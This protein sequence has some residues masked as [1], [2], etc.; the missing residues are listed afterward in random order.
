MKPM[1]TKVEPDQYQSLFSEQGYVFVSGA[2][3]LARLSQFEAHIADGAKK[4]LSQKHGSSI[5][6]A[7]P[8]I[9]RTLSYA[10]MESFRLVC[11]SAG[12]S[13]A[14]LS[15][16][17]EPRLLEAVSKV[18]GR[19][20]A[21]LYPTTPAIFWNDPKAKQLQYD[22]HQEAAY[23]PD[24]THSF[25]IWFPLFRDLEV[26]DGPM[27]VCKGSHKQLFDYERV[28]VEGG[29]T[30]LRVAD[31]IANQFDHIPCELKRGDAILFHPNLIHKTLENHSNIPRT[32]GI[33]RFFP[34]LEEQQYAPV[35]GPL[36]KA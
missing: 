20:A 35:L 36:A 14:G 27:V 16:V 11:R 29:L 19:D 3:D 8:E 24:R 12:T 1:L 34:L 21:S 17:L 5:P 2:L 33:I 15:L 10:D 13:I 6:E 30:Q 25:H 26:V 31:S 22:W 4:L 32:S 9:L 23:Y 7:P 28:P 18:S